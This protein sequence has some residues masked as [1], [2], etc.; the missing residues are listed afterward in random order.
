MILP[1]KHISPPRALLTI[2]AE[3]LR[4]LERPRTVSALWDLLR[5]RD[6]IAVH[7]R[8]SYDWF[9]LTLD[10]LFLVNAIDYRNGTLHRTRS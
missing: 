2:G 3:V 6:E 7:G 1:T 10:L 5:A 9:V 8:I 4:T